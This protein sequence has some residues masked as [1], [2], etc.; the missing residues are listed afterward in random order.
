MNNKVEIGFQNKWMMLP[1]SR[2]VPS[3]MITPR[4]MSTKKFEQISV[5]IREVGIVEPLM[6]HPVCGR[7]REYLVLDGHLRLEVLK[8]LSETDAPC[9]IAKDDEAFTYNKRINRVASVQEHHMILRA[10]KSGVPEDRIA[11]ALGIKVASVRRKKKLLE[12]ICPE[13]VKIL[14][15]IQFSADTAAI[16]KRMKPIR[17]IEVAEVMVATNNFTKSYAKALLIS[18]NESQLLVPITKKAIKGISNAEYEKMEQEMET[19]RRDVKAVED[20]YGINMLRLVVANGFIGR[21][22]E[23]TRI[24]KFLG[25]NHS[26]IFERLLSLQDSID[27]DMGIAAE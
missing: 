1:I 19:L 8:T 6:V 24:S 9:L 26:D 27:S 18:T 13:V 25:R 17:Q 16:L 21:V 7:K 23:N 2:L 15:N 22:L 10:I 11:T 12:G 5:S 3:K 20:T 14:H 4:T